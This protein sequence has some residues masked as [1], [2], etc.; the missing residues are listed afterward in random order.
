MS[1]NISSKAFILSFAWLSSMMLV[2]AQKTSP[3]YRQSFFEYSDSGY[4]YCLPWNYYNPGNENAGYPLVI[5]LHGGGG[6][7]DVAGLDFLGSSE[8]GQV[9]ND[10]SRE[11]QLSYPSFI[12]VPKAKHGWNPS[13]LIPLVED[14]TSRYRVDKKRIY[15]I[16]YSMGGSG[17]YII[18]NGYYDYNQTLFAGIIRLAGQSQSVLRDPIVSN[19][20]VWIH[21]GLDDNPRRVEVSREAY[22]FYLSKHPGASEVKEEIN[23]DGRSGITKTILLDGSAIFKLSE[24]H[25]TGHEVYRFPFDDKN[26]MAWLFSNRIE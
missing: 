25:G 14:F 17:S 13:E 11:F 2:T 16:G 23:I 9:Q 12:L 24:Y 4:Y 10:V 8:E 7:G 1:V 21:I 22:D 6:L 3:E 26:V 19:T 18:A 15:L 20:S 5:Y